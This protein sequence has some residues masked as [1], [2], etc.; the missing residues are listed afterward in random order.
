[1]KPLFLMKLAASF[2]RDISVPTYRNAD[3]RDRV[4]FGRVIVDEGQ[5]LTRF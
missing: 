2:D 5:L 1:M 4:D 3:G